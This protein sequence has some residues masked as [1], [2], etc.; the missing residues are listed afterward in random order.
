MMDLTGKK[1]L[2]VG[3][4]RSGIGASLILNRLGARVIATDT[5]SEEDLKTLFNST[6]LMVRAEE[7]FGS[8]D[9]TIKAGGHDEKDFLGSDLIIISPGVKT[10][11]PLLKE[12]RSKGIEVI[13]ELELAYRLIRAGLTPVNRDIPFYAVTGTNGKSTVTTLLGESLRDIGMRVFI[14]GN[15]GK[16]I[17]LEILRLMEAKAESP[18]AFV[19]EVSSFQ[20]ETIK[21][22]RPSGATILNITPDHLDRYTS[23]DEYIDAKA[24]MG[25]NMKDNDFIVLNHDDANVMSI[26]KRFK[27]F[28]Y[29]FSRRSAVQGVYCKDGIIFINIQSGHFTVLEVD[30]L[31]IKGVHNIENS[32]AALLMAY[33]IAGRSD[34]MGGVLESIRKTLMEFKGL[35][36][37]MEFVAEIDGVSFINDSKGTNVGALMKS[38]EGIERVI[39]IAGGR[40]KKGDFS[41]LRPLVSERV[42]ALVLIGE[43]REKIQRALGDLV[44][45][46]NASDMREAIYK[47]REIARPGDTVLLSPGCASF[48]MFRDF[49]ERGRVFKDIVMGLK[50]GSRKD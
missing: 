50:N 33:L 17:T 38:L 49:E 18:Q 11:M 29:Y 45:T 46:V 7:L 9:I 25:I 48:D 42:K 32:M 10:D 31:K 1:I 23:M 19:V 35:E 41:V 40:D 8:R 2:V 27:A 15:I 13:G 37:R 16:A 26:R 5:R 6:D 44:M 12:A 4:Q 39:L 21:D 20:L 36:H 3:L 47:A 22:F 43:A 30:K 34:P 24:S 28:T 14:C